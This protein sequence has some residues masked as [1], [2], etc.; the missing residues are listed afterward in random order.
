MIYVSGARQL[1]VL[2]KVCL[3]VLA[4]PIFILDGRYK[5]RRTGRHTFLS[6]NSSWLHSHISYIIYMYIFIYIFI[7]TSYI[8]EVATS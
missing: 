6:T 5:N 8:M 3:L 4:T 1:V 7:Y 2:K